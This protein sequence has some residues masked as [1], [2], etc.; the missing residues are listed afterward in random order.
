MRAIYILSIF[1]DVLIW[2][3]QSRQHKWRHVFKLWK[4]TK[5]SSWRILHSCMYI[6]WQKGD[7]EITLAHL[8]CV[9][10]IYRRIHATFVDKI[11]ECVMLL[12][13]VVQCSFYRKLMHWNPCLRNC[14]HLWSCKNV[15]RQNK[16][17]NL[18]QGPFNFSSLGIPFK[19][20]PFLLF[21]ISIMW[22]K[23]TTFKADWVL[24]L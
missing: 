9:Q 24:Q 19:S 6:V 23:V 4:K 22:C 11:S 7:F 1:C 8:T 10:M 21:C 14:V 3:K 17:V 18:I 16:R 13:L 2:K 5:L 15:V 20:G 12:L